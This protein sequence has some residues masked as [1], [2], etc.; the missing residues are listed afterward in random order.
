[1]IKQYSY[2]AVFAETS[3]SLY[4]FVVH[5]VVPFVGIEQHDFEE[6]WWP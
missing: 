5:L 4:I 6:S 1:M 2:S 3:I